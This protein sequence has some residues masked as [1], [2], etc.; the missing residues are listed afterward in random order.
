MKTRNY[1]ASL[2]ECQ[3]VFIESKLYLIEDWREFGTLI[4][5]ASGKNKGKVVVNKIGKIGKIISQIREEAK[6]NR[7]L[8]FD[9]RT[10]GTPLSA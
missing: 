5:E 8:D 4:L 6:K 9:K 3:L 2:F 1:E 10:I 7:V